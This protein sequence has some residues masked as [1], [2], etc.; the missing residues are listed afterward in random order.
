MI[1][2]LNETIEKYMT[3]EFVVDMLT[4]YELYYHISLGNFVMETL[5]DY[6]ETVKKLKELN[7]EVEVNVA[8]ATIVELIVHLYKTEKFEETF[9]YQLRSRAILKALKDFVNGDVELINSEDYIS[10]KTEE[11]ASDTYFKESMKVQL[12]SDY[13]NVNEYYDL[14]ITDEA[15]RKIK[16]SLK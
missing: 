13:T 2:N 10:L 3:R 4:R 9:E 5:Q 8:L 6:D 11:I 15:L 7:L 12:E 16:N 1:M 14:L